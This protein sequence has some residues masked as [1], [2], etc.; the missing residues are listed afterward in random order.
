MRSDIAYVIE[1]VAHYASN[2][3]NDH[4][5]AVLIMLHYLQ[6]MMNYDLIYMKHDSEII[7][8]SDSNYADDVSIH[9]FTIKYVFYLVRE[10]I[11]VRSTLMKMIALSTVKTE[12]IT[13]CSAVQ[14]TL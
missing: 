4:K 13:L 7:D 2:L 10:L 6:N 8:Y 12:Y 9:H 3:S 5:R 11:T 14:E 1:V